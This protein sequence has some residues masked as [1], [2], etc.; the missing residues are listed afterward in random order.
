MFQIE[1]ED[2][3]ESFVSVHNSEF[4]FL[5]KSDMRIPYFV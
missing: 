3:R 2:G 5:D 1:T 4:L